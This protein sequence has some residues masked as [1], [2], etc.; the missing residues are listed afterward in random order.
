MNNKNQ[1][2]QKT[3]R[4]TT[5]AMYLCA[6]LM[7]AFLESLLPPL[8]V[9]GLKLGLANLAVLCCSY[10]VGLAD[11]A[12]VA[13]SRCLLTG[14]LFG[15]GTSLLFSLSGT[16]CVL[17]ALLILRLA[18]RIVNGHLSFIGIS[19]LTA[20]AH[21]L[22]QLSCAALLY[23]WGFSILSV[24]GGGLLLAGTVCGALTGQIA[25]LLLGRLK[26]KNIRGF[27]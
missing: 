20:A 22:G 25:N 3:G 23:G 11:G 10:S 12:A 16:L 5:D 27:L 2:F 17:A 4:L 6:A 15:S 14:L 13:L 18:G 8:P 26:D 24:Y 9:P 19:I 7:L 21:H 1:N